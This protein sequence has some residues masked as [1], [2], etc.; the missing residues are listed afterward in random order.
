MSEKMEGS[1][2]LLTCVYRQGG[3]RVEAV[4]YDGTLIRYTIASE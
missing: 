4:F 1:L 3:E 2:N